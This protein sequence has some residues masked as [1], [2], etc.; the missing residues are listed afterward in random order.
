MYVADGAN[1]RVEEFGPKGEF[2]LM[3]GKEVNKTERERFELNPGETIEQKEAKEDVCDPQT[4][5][6]VECRAGTPSSSPGGFDPTVAM[7]VAV[8][9]DGSSPSH[10]DVYVGVLNEKV[11]AANRVSKFTASGQLV[12][13]WGK[14]PRLTAS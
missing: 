13:S 14:A 1:N 8:D 12:S 6:L 11:A 5:L 9:N 4:D 2:V 3:F 10:G 7:F